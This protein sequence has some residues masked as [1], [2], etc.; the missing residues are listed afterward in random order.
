MSDR[1]SWVKFSV[2]RRRGFAGAVTENDF[3]YV[4]RVDFSRLAP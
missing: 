2:C 3:G 1:M 4:R